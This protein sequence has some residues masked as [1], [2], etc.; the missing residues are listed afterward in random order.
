MALPKI[1]KK[2]PRTKSVTVRLS[3]NTAKN[4]RVLAEEHN[5]SQADVIEH[6]VENAMGE[7]LKHNTRKDILTSKRK[8]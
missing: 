8:G 2:D 4:L 6:L 7:F 5:M 3:E 1:P